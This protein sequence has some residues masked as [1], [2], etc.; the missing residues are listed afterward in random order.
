MRS[1]QRS[2]RAK[3]QIRIVCAPKIAF[4][5][6][7]INLNIEGTQIRFQNKIV[8]VFLKITFIF[9]CVDDLCP[10]QQFFSHVRTF[11]CLAESNQY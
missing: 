11:S 9:V 4:I 10:R 5:S 3:V 7:P 2:L 6:L 8:F 1:N